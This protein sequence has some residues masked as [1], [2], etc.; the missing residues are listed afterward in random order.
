MPILAN[1]LA[2][3]FEYFEPRYELPTLEDFQQEVS[4]ELMRT[5]HRSTGRA[6]VTLPTG[7]GKTLVAVETI[8]NWLTANFDDGP[9]QGI[10]WLAHTEELCEQAYQCF[11]QVWNRST[12]S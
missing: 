10:L 3:D 11:A 8:K 12:T 9:A 2:E 6:I 1:S 5:L 4:L 7:A